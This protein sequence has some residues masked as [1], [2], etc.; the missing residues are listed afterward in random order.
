MKRIPLS[1]IKGLT[2]L[3]WAEAAWGYHNQYV[4]WS[5]VVD[6][7]C[8]CLAE[9]EDESIV[10]E[11]AGLSKSEASEA[12]QLL[13]KLAAKAIDGDE[14]ARKAKWLYL[15]L[16]WLFE[17]RAS[18]PDPLEAVEELYSDFDYPEDVAQFVRYMPVTDGYDPSAHSNEENH[19]RLL[20]KWRSYL[21]V[22]SPIFTACSKPPPGPR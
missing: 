6:M 9:N 19:S 12:G 13:D 16:A 20:S 17:N 5:D 21:E 3:S 18:S 1:F 10:V 15:S 7:A 14:K 8:D 2:H 11:L 4:G 22:K